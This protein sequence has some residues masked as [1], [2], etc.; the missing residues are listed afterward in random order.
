MN[1]PMKP[2]IYYRAD[3]EEKCLS[4]R[5]SFPWSPDSSR[6]YV[7]EG[8]IWHDNR[9]AWLQGYRRV[10]GG[11][12]AHVAFYPGD[13][14]KVGDTYTGSP[15]LDRVLEIERRKYENRRRF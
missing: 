5:A 14:V 6:D 10:E 9:L 7:L 11:M 4:F 8:L 1:K 3:V 15:W 13:L 12:W 2:W